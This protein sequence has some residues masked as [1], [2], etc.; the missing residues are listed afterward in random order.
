MFIK[1]TTVFKWTARW[2][3]VRNWNGESEGTARPVRSTTGSTSAESDREKRWPLLLLLSLS[4]LPRIKKEEETRTR[5]EERERKGDTKKAPSGGMGKPHR[6]MVKGG[7]STLKIYIIY[8]YMCRERERKKRL[9]FLV[10][11]VWSRFFLCVAHLSLKHDE[12]PYRYQIGIERPW[13][14]RRHITAEKKRSKIFSSY[15][16]FLHRRRSIIRVPT[17][18]S[19]LF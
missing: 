10:A 6:K 7:G 16:D 19:I 4:L 13:E 18:F 1:G 11:V 14:K 3:L 2:C 9:F 5:R 15:F 8:I 12:G 17:F